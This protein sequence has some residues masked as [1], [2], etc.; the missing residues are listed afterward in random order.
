MCI[1]P[2]RRLLP[3]ADADC[4]AC[5][6]VKRL[7]RRSFGV[8]LSLVLCVVFGYFPSHL[9]P[10]LGRSGVVRFSNSITEKISPALP[11]GFV[12]IAASQ[13][14]SPIIGMVRRLIYIRVDAWL[15]HLRA[16][17]VAEPRFQN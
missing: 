13:K 7:N 14:L 17:G 16:F 12:N 3:L 6:V 1:Y 5:Y 2:N 9:A 10:K 15:N 4:A 11:C 8:A